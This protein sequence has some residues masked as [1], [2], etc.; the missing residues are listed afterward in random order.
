[1]KEF[2]FGG[3]S[4]DD[5]P[6]DSSNT[7]EAQE[8]DE[9]VESLARIYDL[10]GNLK[11]NPPKNRAELRGNL[12]ELEKPLLD[13]IMTDPNHAVLPSGEFP[14]LPADVHNRLFD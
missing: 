6:D 13:V 1:M 7:G 12:R 5:E 3:E 9:A 8:F 14:T 4:Q 11:E 2:R 10:F